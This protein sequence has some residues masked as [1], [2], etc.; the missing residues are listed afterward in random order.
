MALM[1]VVSKLG[2]VSEEKLSIVLN[3][4]MYV[5]FVLESLLLLLLLIKKD[6]WVCLQHDQQIL[7]PAL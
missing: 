3:L 7:C 1:L 5:T 2:F 6:E 4:V